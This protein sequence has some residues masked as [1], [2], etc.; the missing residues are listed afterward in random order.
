[1]DVTEWTLANRNS[2]VNEIVEL[3]NIES[4]SMPTESS[5]GSP[6]GFGCRKVLDAA[7][8]LCDR[9]GFSPRNHEYYCASF[10]WKGQSEQELGIFGHLDVV[11]AGPGW[12][13]E[14]F[15]ATV[16]D[17]II[18]GR[19]AADNK[20]A[21]VAVLYALKFLRESGYKPQNSIRMVI[22]SNE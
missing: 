7:M 9:H 18:V 6:F 1:M 3:V 11:P 12:T 10:L 4:V 5:E 13:Y 8:T 20:G 16:L 17:D 19:G 22:G 14:P 21:V 2:M 15:N